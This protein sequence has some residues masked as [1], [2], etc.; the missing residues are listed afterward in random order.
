M[1]SKSI[2]PNQREILS[3]RSTLTGNQEYLTST[4][5]ILNVSSSGGG[6]GAVTVAD[7]AD[8]AEG[9][10]T[11]AAVTAGST[12]TVSGKLRQI[13]AD[14]SSGNTAQ[15]TTA[16]QTNGTQQAKITDGTNI[17]NT[18]KSDG[19]AAG[20]NSL[21]IAGSYLS[22]A[23]TTTTVQAVGTTDAGDY[24]YVSVHQTAAGGSSVTN[25]QGSNDNTNW[26]TVALSQPNNTLSSPSLT[27]GNNTIYSGPL[28][29]RYFRL[30]ITG[31]ASGTTSGTIVFFTNRPSSLTTIAGQI[32]LNGTQS[33][34]TTSATGSAVPAN[35][36]YQGISDGTNLR[37][38]LGAANAL[39][40]TGAGIPTAQVIGQFDD[41]S[42][43]AI[44]ENQ[45][46][47]LRMS[48]NRNLYGT[49]RDAAGNERGA[50]VTASNALVVDG[51]AVTQPVS[52]TSTT[53]TSQVPGTGATNLGKAEDAAHTSGDVGVFALGVSNE[54]Q[55]SLAADGDYIA[56]STD[57]KGNRL[58]VG[59]L[60]SDAVDAGFPVKTGGQA[61][62][63]N[64]TAVADA[65]R[66][67]FIADKLGKQV[68]VGSVRDLKVNQITTITASTAETTVVTAVA[69]TF[70]DVYG[71]IV[72]NTSATLVNIAFKDSTAGTTQFNLSVPANDTRGFTL[73]ESA[74]IKQG[75]V[76]N[77]WT[78]T[79]SASVSSLVITM[80]AVK[81]T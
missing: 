36:F 21:M 54:A 79:S 73:P 33:I 69:S 6:G 12:G 47:N 42:P 37:G 78:A 38:L 74:A 43:T 27:G 18:L 48:A 2:S 4:S 72:S 20:Q 7:G 5:G 58:V 35:A 76:N 50:N 41:V 55:T 67:N 68:V 17:T 75:T 51:S 31:I 52:L 64:P 66:V 60:A 65:D 61:R 15:A 49:I 11:D 19:T 16:N 81:N 57:T 77:N 53:I 34:N 13:S 32:A 25:F 70:L 56:Q 1:A 46:G 3:A 28:Q 39:N 24:N 26:V 22:V 44:T 23:F 45:F 63:T 71:V 59:N 9:A 10:T 62:T 30:S 29:Y 14:I 8:V 80:L 40:S